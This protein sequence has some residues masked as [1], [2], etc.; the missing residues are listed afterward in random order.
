MIPIVVRGLV[1]QYRDGTQANRGLDLDVGPGEIVAILGPNGAGKTTFLRQ[2][3]TEL[4]PSAGSIHVFGID[5]IHEPHA[6]KRAMGI[7]P[8]EA[9]LFDALSVREHVGLFGR[10]KRI[11]AD[12]CAAEADWLLAELGLSNVAARR[13]GTLSGGQR[14]R[15]LIGLALLGR[16][17]LLI[18]DEPTSG[19]DPASRRGVWGVLR[20]AVAN[21][22]SIVFSTH[23]MEEA[24]HLSDRVAIVNEGRVIACGSVRELMARVSKSYRVSWADDGGELQVTRWP[25]FADAQAAVAR[26][27]L[28]EY[29]I[30][31]ASLEDVYFELVGAPYPELRGEETVAR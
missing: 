16:P 5:A 26:C 27:G 29:T 11:P 18:L 20:R 13:V 1:K 4:R 15:I 2:L 28:S 10:L 22:A 14:R 17:P 23:Y 6:A 9:G 30:A 19:L 31:R 7:T 3:T 21:G 24:E 8:Q 12:R 25:T